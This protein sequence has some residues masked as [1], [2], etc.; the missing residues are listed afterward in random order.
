MNTL[1]HFGLTKTVSSKLKYNVC[2]SC[3][4]YLCKMKVLLQNEFI[5]YAYTQAYTG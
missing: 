4:F 2:L 5:F 3:N 1:V